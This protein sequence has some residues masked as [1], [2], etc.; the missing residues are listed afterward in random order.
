MGWRWPTATRLHEHTPWHVARQ[1][2][3]RPA[4]LSASIARQLEFQLGILSLGR[5]RIARQTGNESIC[6]SAGSASQLRLPRLPRHP[7][8][9]AFEQHAQLR[10]A[11]HF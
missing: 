5:H 8:V 6:P 7:P 2:L 3:R 10:R 4:E 1:L 9:D 11:D